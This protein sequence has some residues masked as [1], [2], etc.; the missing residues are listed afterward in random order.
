MTRITAVLAL[1]FSL[2]FAL[3][4]AAQWTTPRT[5]VVNEIVTAAQLNAQIRDNLNEL[6]AGGLAVSSQAAGD[7]LCASSTTQLGRIAAGAAGTLLASDSTST[8]PFYTSRSTSGRETYLLENTGGHVQ[9]KIDT[10]DASSGPEI[11]FESPGADYIMRIDPATDYF[12]IGGEL[13]TTDPG[14]TIDENG[15]VGIGN[16]FG[17]GTG[18]SSLF[19]VRGM[20]TAGLMSVS[21]SDGT[22]ETNDTL[23]QIRFIAPAEGSGGDAV[24]AGAAITAVVEQNFDA[25]T[26]ATALAF[27]TETSASATERMRVT[28][29]GDVWVG[30][31]SGVGR[32]NLYD[33]GGG[34]QF[35]YIQNADTGV[36]STDGLQIGID[37]SERPFFWSYESTDMFFATGNA[38]RM[39]ID[40]AG[41]V[42]VAGTLEVGPANVETV[43]AS[44]TLAD[45]A[46]TTFTGYGGTIEI[47]TT[48]QDF[49]CKWTV[50]G[51][52]ND[53]ILID[54]ADGGC[55]HTDGTANKIN[56]DYA[57]GAYR[58]ENTRGAQHTLIVLY[59][60]F[61]Q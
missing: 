13:L 44:V 10:A 47:Y 2:L 56:V 58:I 9:L 45:G 37:A 43:T 48:T 12:V 28:G 59:Q 60:E 36:T 61:E 5:W 22:V 18:P 30:T 49:S 6:R 29:D 50:K 32:L 15:N 46:D 14:I 54:D 25:T 1:L 16:A 26:N 8:C 27:S 3:P 39:T 35:V 7:L 31:T 23:G 33:A 55:S 19:D 52:A 20:T 24:L 11:F 38:T 51:S 4:A 17:A 41:V 34:D 57:T 42:D 53:T 21:N 40:S